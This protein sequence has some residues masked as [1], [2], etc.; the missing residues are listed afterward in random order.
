MNGSQLKSYLTGLIL[1]DGHLDHGVSKRAFR[2]KSINLDF[3]YKIQS[4]L[5]F[6]D[7]KISIKEFPSWIGKD[8]TH[9]KPYGELFIK[10]HPYFSKIYHHFYDDFGKRIISKWAL[11]NLDWN[12]FA[13][14]FMGDGY[15]IKVGKES[16]NIVDRRVEICTDR[17]SQ[18]DVLYLSKYLENKFQ[19]KITPVKRNPTRF[20]VRIHLKNAQ[21]FLFNISPFIVPSFFYKLDLAY[22]YRPD[23]M[24]DDYYN[25]MTTL[26]ERQTSQVDDEIV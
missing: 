18:K 23:W 2:I 25:L 3:L 14:W 16:G 1:G 11:E 6:S 20:R 22:E 5:A 17:Y 26:H 12:G 7:F 15:I 8:G 10:S 4:D 19:Y 13:N 21:D 24:N 9:H